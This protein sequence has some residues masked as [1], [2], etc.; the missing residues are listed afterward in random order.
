MPL[1]KGRR[2]E[3]GIER[4]DS[5]FEAIRDHLDQQGYPPSIRWIA[6]ELGMAPSNVS[7]HIGKLVEDGRISKDKNVSRGIRINRDVL[8]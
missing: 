2:T 4:T 7:Y 6:A 8:Y 3:S 5:V 1:P